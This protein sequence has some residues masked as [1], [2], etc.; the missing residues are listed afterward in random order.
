MRILIFLII[1][2]LAGGAAWYYY[3]YV[4]EPS[5]NTVEKITV[6]DTLVI[7]KDSIINASVFET[8]P[9]GFYQGTFPCKNCEG[10]QRTIAF[11]G[12]ANFKMEELNRGKGTAARK[13][14]GTWKK[15]K[16]R[17]VFYQNNKA[18]SKYRLTKDSLIN[19]ENNGT[20][21][22]DSL[23]KQYVLFKKNT[24]PENPSW[25][26]RKSEGIDIIGN[27]SDPAWNIEIDAEKLILFRL[28]SEDKP[29]IVP[30]ENAI[31]T[32]DSTVYSITSEAGSVLRVSIYS[33]FCHDG[34]GDHLY[35]YKMTVRYKGQVYKGCAFILDKEHR[36]N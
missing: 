15:E 3:T 16:D 34:I 5:G 7:T 25:K 26:I 6:T 13:T 32:K 14:E 4:Y 30:V 24:V 23:S 11:S 36:I 21:I 18:I 29:V 19:T 33:S 10:I 20:R 28:A 35:E 17:F 2:A 22:P 31:V 27:G 8:T 1:V 12:E 9:T